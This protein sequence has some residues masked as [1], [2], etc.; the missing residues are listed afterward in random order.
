M[1]AR[2]ASVS[3]ALAVSSTQVADGTVLLD[4]RCG[5]I[6]HLNH[7]GAVALSALLD[8]GYEAAVIALCAR[9]TITAGIARRDLTRLLAEL[10]AHRLVTTS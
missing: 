3:L 6:Y 10:L 7:T 5:M 1:P 9:Y 4:E 8:G 2:P